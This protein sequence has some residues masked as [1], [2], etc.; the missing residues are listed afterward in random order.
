VKH[1]ATAA[2]FVATLLAGRTLLRAAAADDPGSRVA[3]IEGWLNA[4]FEHEPGTPDSIVVDISG[5]SASD[6]DVFRIDLR[7]FVQLM[8][9]PWLTSFQLPSKE[10]DCTDCFA[11][12]RDLT[13]TRLLRPGEMIRY[14]D[15][16]LHRLKVLACAAA[17]ML[18]SVECMRLNADREIDGSLRRFAAR[19]TAARRDGDDSYML[20]RAALLHTD[21]A[22][23]TAGTLSPIESN[24][25]ESEPSVRVHM[26]DGE[27]ASVGIGEIHWAIGRDLIDE[28]RPRPDAMAR[29]WY[30]ATGAWM[31]REQQYDPVHLQRAREL[32][33]DDAF[34]LFLSGTHAETFA[35]PAIQSALKTAVLPTG[36]V[37]KMGNE[38]SELK[39]AETML[40]RA[41]Q[42]DPSFPEAHL[43]FGHV[44]LARGKPQEA[45]VELKATVTQDPLLRYYA[46]MFLGAAE[47]ALSHPDLARAAYE[48]AAAL[49][50]RAQSPALA[51][52][53]LYAGRSDRAAARTAIGPAFDLPVAAE[54]GDDPWWRY[55][56]V[57]GRSAGDLLARLRAPFLNAASR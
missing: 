51:L 32:F 28:V 35:S 19:A 53:A 9:K 47:E 57:Q 30:M 2:V 16:Q 17:G 11:A 6:L 26:V 45:V 37:L 41:V 20:R 56:T 24:A 14:T 15:A 48:R 55:R 10:V 52:S 25:S 43:H 21:V 22:M 5:W 50:P 33:K 4:I 38:P 12:R 36:L 39:T 27:T 29:L 13:Q 46:Q 34:I 49:F 7:V 40:Q 42:I 1:L 8:R 44:L 31:Q 23:V 54:D 3:R 18:D